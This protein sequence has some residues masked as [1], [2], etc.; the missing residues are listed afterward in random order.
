MGE[1]PKRNWMTIQS[2]GWFVALF[3]LYMQYQINRTWQQVEGEEVCSVLYILNFLF[4]TV[5]RRTGGVLCVWLL[6]YKFKGPSSVNHAVPRHPVLN[7]FYSVWY[8][9][10]E[11]FR[12]ARQTQ[13]TIGI[14]A[15]AGIGSVYSAAWVVV[16]IKYTACLPPTISY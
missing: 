13:S 2:D 6:C 11:P 7:S 14:A 8:F 5:R 4:H 12:S 1:R 10:L 15:A 3:S 16:Y 9:C